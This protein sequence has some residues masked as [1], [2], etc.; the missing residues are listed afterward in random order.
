MPV[1][2]NGFQALQFID[3][4]LAHG[5]KDSPT[6]Y[7]AETEQTY[8]STPIKMYQGYINT[9]CIRALNPCYRD[10]SLVRE[11]AVDQEQRETISSLP[12]T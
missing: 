9:K 1:Y 8:I 2:F 4:F 12:K 5:I 11:E 6:R 7:Q 10:C 3:R